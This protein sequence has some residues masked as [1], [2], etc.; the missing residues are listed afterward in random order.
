[1]RLKIDVIKIRIIQI[2]SKLLIFLIFRIGKALKPSANKIVENTAR[3][4]NFGALNASYEFTGLN[5]SVVEAIA[6]IEIFSAVFL[7]L[8]VFIFKL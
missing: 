8:W 5:T 6:K 3:A 4:K 7:L 2:N 1:M